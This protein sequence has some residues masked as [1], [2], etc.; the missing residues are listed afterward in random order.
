MTVIATG[1]GASRKSHS[2]INKKITSL[3]DKK[4]L[5]LSTA[6]R[7]Y[8]ENP[9]KVSSEK[10]EKI[11]EKKELEEESKYLDIPSFVRTQ[12]D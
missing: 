9:P 4:S 10:E 7:E 1:L 2:P 3:N 12:L 8:L 11:K 5:P 6:S